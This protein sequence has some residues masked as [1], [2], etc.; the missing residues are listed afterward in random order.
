MVNEE[1]QPIEYTTRDVNIN[2]DINNSINENLMNSGL[3]HTESNP[4]T[5]EEI[6]NMNNLNNRTL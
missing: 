4:P 6:V 5:T 2:N 1:E 3:S